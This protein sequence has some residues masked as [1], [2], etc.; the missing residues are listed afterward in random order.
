MFAKLIMVTAV[1]NNKFYIMQSNPDN[2]SFTATYGRVGT[3]G[4][5][6]VYP[7]SKWNQKYNEKIRKGYADVTALVETAKKANPADEFKPIEDADIAEVIDF[8]AEM[9]RQILAKNYSVSLDAVTPEMVDEAQYILNRLAAQR[10]KWEFNNVLLQLFQA[11]PR[12]MSQVQGYMMSDYSEKAKIISREQDLLDVMRGQIVRTTAKALKKT[13]D[14]DQTILDAIG[15]SMRPVSDR[16]ASDIK[17]HLG[18]QSE[19]YYRA[20]RVVNDRTQKAFDN[21]MEANA[22]C[23]R[24]MLWHGSKNENWLNI[25][26]TGLVLNPNAVATGKMFGMGIYFAPS[27]SK[28]V[29][30][31][32]LT[33]SY[34]AGGTSSRAFMAVMDVACGKP[35]DI[36]DNPYAWSGLNAQNLDR[37]CKGA[38]YVF[39]HKDKGMLRNDELVVYNEAQV[40]IH[41]LVE[42]KA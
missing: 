25:L 18:R 31:T 1:N 2:T 10:D 16:E 41:Y 19:H 32:S 13:A 29:G 22:S 35:F 12:E 17:R 28:S 7:M 30:Y 42:L 39:A 36:Y 24:K 9:S 8:L 6:A 37:H 14:S 21:Y 33:G 38:N 11:L 26:K 3:A 27:A 23:E 20:W 34:W 5:C 4:Q 15:V 40:T